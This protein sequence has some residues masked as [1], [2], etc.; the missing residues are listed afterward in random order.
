[1]P[2]LQYATGNPWGA[3]YCSY[4]E[5]YML[6]Q[7]AF[8]VSTSMVPHCF[9]LPP[10]QGMF[11]PCLCV[12]STMSVPGLYH[13]PLQFLHIKIVWHLHKCVKVQSAKWFVLILK[14]ILNYNLDD[15]KFRKVLD[16]IQIIS[17]PPPT[18]ALW[19]FLWH[20][21]EGKINTE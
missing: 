9:R 19:R 11:A 18:P 6:P 17:S 20:N 16:C 12:G 15:L 13:Q 1:M 4:L 7:Q 2:P 8:A 14:L 21:I 5:S 10:G 3:P